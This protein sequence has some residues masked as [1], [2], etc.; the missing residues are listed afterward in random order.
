[1]S[2]RDFNKKDRLMGRISFWISFLFWIGGLALM[3]LLPTVAFASF[4]INIIDL[5]ESYESIDVLM[6]NPDTL[7]GYALVVVS[8]I[9][10]SAG[11]K[12]IFDIPYV[13]KCKS[14]PE[15]YG[16]RASIGRLIFCAI[17][18]IVGIVGLYFSFRVTITI[19]GQ[20]ISYNVANLGFGSILFLVLTLT[21]E[22]LSAIL[23][24]YMC[25]Q[26]KKVDAGE[27]K[28]FAKHMTNESEA[29]KV[30]FDSGTITH[31][32]YK[33]INKRIRDKNSKSSE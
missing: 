22:A 23:D 17:I 13:I 7:I 18:L 21:S 4:G 12:A 6:E 27:G 8:L 15:K 28:S 26:V 2:I 24:I 25:F 16:R 29:L 20:Q 9:L 19:N 32:E 31:K 5:I 1:M 33:K 14:L 30:L 10:I 3:L 11:A